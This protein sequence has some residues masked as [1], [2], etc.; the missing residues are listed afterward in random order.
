MGLPFLSNLSELSSMRDK[1][2]PATLGS[3]ELLYRVCAYIAL[4]AGL[5]F[6]VTLFAI[7]YHDRPD[8]LLPDLALTMN[9]KTVQGQLLHVEAKVSSVKA[10]SKKQKMVFRYAIPANGTFEGYSY[11][12]R[13]AFGIGTNVVVEYLP[14]NPAISRIAGTDAA[15]IHLIAFGLTASVFCL[16]FVLLIVSASQRSRLRHVMTNGETVLA[17]INKAGY[18]KTRGTAKSHPHIISYSFVDRNGQNQIGEARYWPVNSADQVEI[19]SKG[20]KI[21]VRYLRDNPKYS[22]VLLKKS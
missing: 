20:D 10:G 1:I 7:Q 17:I 21:V 3:A 4:V 9:G 14:D 8:S 2:E 12:V 18:D 15:K 13:P 5:F 22:V 6:G 16:G 19:P 11:Q